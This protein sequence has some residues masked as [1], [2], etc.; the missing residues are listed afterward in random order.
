MEAIGCDLLCAPGHKSLLGPLGTGIMYVADAVADQIKP[1]RFGGTGTDGSVEFQ[2]ENAPDKFEAGNLNLPGI[3]GLNAGLKFLCS[4]EG[5][6]SA[7]S[8]KVNS[9]LL[10]EGLNS[11]KGVTLQGLPTVEGRLGVFSVVVEGLGCHEVAGILDST[12]S[13]QTRA[14]LHCAPMLHRALQTEEQGGT[15]RLSVG[16]FNTREE[17]QMALDSLARLSASMV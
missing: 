3:A 4:D 5:L 11:I 13:I 17:I 7:E 8:W 1:L 14:G 12:W 2:P 6:A 16:R 10:L 15:L 9:R